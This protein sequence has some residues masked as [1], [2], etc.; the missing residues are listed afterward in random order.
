[1]TDQPWPPQLAGEGATGQ[2][3]LD[4]EPAQLAPL[5]RGQAAARALE[6]A[7]ERL[8]DLDHE[9]PCA[10]AQGRLGRSQGEVHGLSLRPA[11]CPWR[12]LDP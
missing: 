10:L 5:R 8:Q 2:P 11:R 9:A 7:L 6:V 1:M 12:A 4:A 3:G